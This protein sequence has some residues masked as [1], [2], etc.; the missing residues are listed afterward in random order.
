MRE[1]EKSRIALTTAGG[2]STAYGT[3][4]GDSLIVGEVVRID[5]SGAGLGGSGYYNIGESGAMVTGAFIAG[6]ALDG[7]E[8]DWND[9]FVPRVK[10]KD[11]SDTTVELMEG[12][13]AVP[14]YGVSVPLLTVSGCNA[15][16]ITMDIYYKPM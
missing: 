2:T 4:Y 10:S 12:S 9:S 16:S 15:G 14:L 13:G 11:S 7:G 3:A 1:I 5:M 8:M 6:S